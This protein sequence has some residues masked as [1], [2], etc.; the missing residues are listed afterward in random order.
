[1]ASSSFG[2][3]FGVVITP[4]P[5]G[6]Y[7]QLMSVE[8]S[9]V[10]GALA[11][12]LQGIALY[13]A[14]QLRR[15]TLMA[16]CLWVATAASC[17]L[18][19]AYGMAQMDAGLGLE[20]LRFVAAASTLCPL[21][22]VLGAKRPQDRGWQWVV[23]SL[24]VIV[25]WPAGQALAKPA[26]PA[27]EI[28]ALWQLFIWALIAMGPFNYLP[29][30]YWWVSLFVAAGQTLL[31]SRYLGVPEPR[32]WFPLAMACFVLA[33][34]VVVMSRRVVVA[35]QTHLAA[36]TERWLAYRNAFGT[37][38]GLRVMQRVN[39]TAA[40]RHWPVQLAWSGFE[41]VQDEVPTAIQAAEI[42]QTLDTLLRRFL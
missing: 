1:M 34:L 33:A 15:T 23:V 22:A 37:F 36:Q 16:P 32:A 20:A 17:L 4:P 31:F 42:D 18:L 7:E 19:L 9:I 24:W 5:P 6:T 11:V 26:G 25:A 29:T 21:I 38:W 35:E 40:L 41:S 27:V 39:E 30:R 10:G 12:L 13:G 8:A 2:K 3:F 14:K 28:I